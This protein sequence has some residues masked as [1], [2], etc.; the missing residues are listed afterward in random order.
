[1][2]RKADKVLLRPGDRIR[3]LLREHN[4]SQEVFADWIGVSRLTINQ[5]INHHRGLTADVALRIAAATLTTPDEWLDLQQRVDLNEAR[6]RLGREIDKIA[7][8]PKLRRRK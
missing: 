1:M 8:L 7:P 2:K 3:G 5:I 6:Q 4:L